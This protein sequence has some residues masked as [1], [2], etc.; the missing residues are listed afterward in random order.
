MHYYSKL[1]L[2]SA[3]LKCK[4]LPQDCHLR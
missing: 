2:S 3:S 1:K 4:P